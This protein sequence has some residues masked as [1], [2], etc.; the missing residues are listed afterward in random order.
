[1]VLSEDH[2]HL[3]HVELPRSTA[4]IASLESAVLA[5]ESELAKAHISLPS[6]T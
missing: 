3:K 2:D 4:T 1:M 6:V 5:L